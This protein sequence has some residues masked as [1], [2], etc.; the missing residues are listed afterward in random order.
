MTAA[1]ELLAVLD[2]F[3]ALSPDEAQDV[4]RI[5]QLASTADPWVRSSP[6]H[7]TGSA[8]IVHPPSGRVLLRWHERM[9][10]WLQVGGHADPGETDPLE[11]ALREA[12]EETAL[13]DLQPWPKPAQPRVVQVAIVPV[14]AGKGEPAHQRY[15]LSTATPEAATPETPTARLAWLDLQQALTTVAEDNLRVCLGRIAELLAAAEHD[16]PT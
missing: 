11:I 7:V 3:E 10:S 4:L 16:R 8:V 2:A 1:T 5:R 14:P 13:A 12:R 15:V 6:L 9:Q